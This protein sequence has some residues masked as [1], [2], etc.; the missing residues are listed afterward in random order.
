MVTVIVMVN[1]TPSESIA[2]ADDHR[3]RRWM[4]RIVVSVLL[5]ILILSAVSVYLVSSSSISFEEVEWICSQINENTT[6]NELERMLG[7]PWMESRQN[8][9]S[10]LRFV[11]PKS[12]SLDQID[13]YVVMM[14]C[15]ET[16]RISPDS[17]YFTQTNGWHAWLA[18]WQLLK[19]K[20]GL[21][22]ELS[23]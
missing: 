15:D 23:L 11:F 21:K 1:A 17:S 12:T 16:G 5:S 22:S 14:E 7:K 20:L 18:R 4:I 9:S 19:L 10:R 8:G 6:R 3:R 13:F 2:L